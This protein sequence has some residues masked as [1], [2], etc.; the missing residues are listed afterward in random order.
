[1]TDVHRLVRTG[2][3]ILV[4]EPSLLFIFRIK[5]LCLSQCNLNL[6]TPYLY[7]DGERLSAITGS[8]KYFY[9]SNVLCFFSEVDHK[10]EI[11]V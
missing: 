5:R 2:Y 7:K 10:V 4:Y 8:T 3:H 1:M 6:V 9:Q 11:T